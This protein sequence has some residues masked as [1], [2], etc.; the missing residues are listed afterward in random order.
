M[1]TV[2][3][4]ALA[5]TPSA[6]AARVATPTSLSLSAASYRV[7]YGHAT[8][9]S[10][11]LRSPARSGVRIVVDAHR[12]GTSA[13]LHAATVRTSADGS[14][15]VR[16][17]PVI[18][19]TYQ[20]H[21]AAAAGLGTVMSRKIAVGVAPSVSLKELPNGR[22]RVRV[23]AW[24]ALNG[25]LVELQ[26]L[27]SKGAWK[28]IDRKPLSSASIA[29]LAP[30]LPTST[31]RAAMSINQ[32]G[33]GYLG[34]ASHPLAYKAVQLWLIPAA[35]KVLFGRALVLNGRLLHARTNQHVTIYSRPYGS[36]AFK[37]L[38]TM[39]TTR[40]GRFHLL[41]QP[42]IQTTYEARLGTTRVSLPVT[43]GVSPDLTVVSLGSRTLRVHVAAARAF[44]GKMV[45]L[46]RKVGPTAWHT[47][48]KAS[49]GRSSTATFHLAPIHSTVRIAMSV[50]QAGAGYLGAFSHPLLVPAV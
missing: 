21:I 14:W 11:R 24:H 50:N 1:L 30:S 5:A 44:T 27:A 23:R 22:L 29:V 2:L 28:T 17:K 12:Y 33:A 37:P 13:P 15:S 42:T 16:V 48:D 6:L 38:E 20:A 18:R 4:V 41:V 49:L 25:K 34:G 32:A 19:T 31:V 43:L 35:Y 10:G 3:L 45:E 40:D 46:Q 47:I 36:G 8:V 39:T 9:I 7:L 26:Q